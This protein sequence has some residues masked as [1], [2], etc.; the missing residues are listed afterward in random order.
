VARMSGRIPRSESRIRRDKAPVGIHVGVGMVVVLVALMVAA[1]LP[2]SAGGWRLTP[3]AAALV[4]IG[5]GTVDPAAVAV[6]A[7][8]AYLLVIGFLVNR[9]GV[10]S[11]HGT[12]DIYRSA[13]IA[14][15]AGAGLVVGVVRRWIRR[16]RSLVVPPEWVVGIAAESRPLTW[17]NKEEF[18]GG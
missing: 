6:V 17:M 13:V 10:L 15:A 11:W 9:Y 12:S 14:A 3:V 4:V 8:L 18:P 16:P 7:S 2:S 1:M 5:A